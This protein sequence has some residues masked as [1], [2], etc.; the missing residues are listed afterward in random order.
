MIFGMRAGGLLLLIGALATGCGRPA[1]R[2][3]KKVPIPASP[4]KLGCASAPLPALAYAE[5]SIFSFLYGRESKIEF[6]AEASHVN[7]LAGSNEYPLAPMTPDPTGVGHLLSLA[8]GP[9]ASGCE[10]SP[11]M[12][13]GGPPAQK[14]TVQLTD[15]RLVDWDLVL[16][17]GGVSRVCV[18]PDGEMTLPRGAL[19]L[20]FNGMSSAP[21]FENKAWWMGFRNTEPAHLRVDFDSRRLELSAELCEQDGADWG[22]SLS[23]QG[24]ITNVPPVAV[25]A[26]RIEVDCTSSAGAEVTLDA[27]SSYDLD[28]DSLSYSWWKNGV[29]WNNERVRQTSYDPKATVTTPPG[30]TVYWVSVMQDPFTSSQAPLEVVVR[31]SQKCPAT[32]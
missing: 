28:G 12:F 24:A 14:M 23:T 16:V 25:T 21:E 9:C 20:Q 30:T 6:D 27:S 2:C 4:T 8:G 18:E 29:G 15:G 3:G 19:S 11:S 26:G 7:V 13:L 1:G 31:P 22:L 5:G 17:F 32:G 10:V